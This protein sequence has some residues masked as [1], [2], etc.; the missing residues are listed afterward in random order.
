MD[1]LLQDIRY[2]LRG[3]ARSPGF[4]AAALLTLA[5]GSGANTTVFGFVNALLLRP[6]PVVSDPASLYSIFTSDFSSGPYGSTSYP[7]F[8]SLQEQAPAFSSLAAYAESSAVLRHGNTTERIRVMT[9]SSEFFSLLGV[10]AR[11][12]VLSAPD[13]AADAASAIVISD[14][15]WQRVF[16]GDEGVLGRTVAINGQPST[17]VGVAPPRFDGLNLGVAIDVWSP[18]IVRAAD[19]AARGSRGLSVL[20][21]LRDDISVPSAQAQLDAIAANLARAYPE[22]NLGTLGNPDRPRPMVLVEHSRM[23]PRFRGMVAM[24]GAVLMSA[25][26]LV[27]LVACANVAGLL[28]SRGAAR[29]REIATRL[30]LGA[31]RRRLVC[32][33]LTESLLLGIAGGALGLLFALWTSDVLPS[34]FPAE[35]ARL[36]DAGI[37]LRVLAFAALASIAT[38][39][40]FGL[41]PAVKTLRGVESPL[42]AGAGRTAEARTGL[43]RSGLVSSQ[44]ALTFVLLVACGLLVRSVANAFSA[45]IGFGTRDV[46]IANVEIPATELSPRQGASYF[47]QLLERVRTLPGVEA[48]SLVRSLSLSSLSRRRFALEGYEPRAGEDME[49]PINVVDAHY[50]DTM[51]IPIVEGRAFDGRDAEKGERTV[52]VNDVLAQRY[53]G[54]RAVGRRIQEG[55]GTVLHVIGVVRSGTLR[56]FQEPPVPTVFYPLAQSYSTRLTL[57]ARTAGEPA[58]LTDTLQTAV[59]DVNRSV[60]VFRVMTLDGHV[61]EALGAERLMAALVTAAG[62]M[63]LLLA[64]VGLYGVI[65][66]GVVRRRREI[67]VRIALG[68]QPVDVVRLVL[69]EGMMVAL[70]GIGLGAFGALAGMRLIASLLYGVSPWDAMTF[71]GAAAVLAAIAAAAAWVPAERAVRLDPAAALRQE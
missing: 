31:S 46:V 63:A 6:A 37:D 41:I 66:Y 18:L 24:V 42:Q 51:R 56:S 4:T 52:I 71:A 10:R 61:S 69:R 1:A 49:L 33:L 58:A 29:S 53:F 36:L 67:S 3:F 30:A 50:F 44:V 45:D 54:G 20:A 7:D 9:V 16:G 21:R 60:A 13:F 12:R 38:G 27:L 23:H 47:A 64:V 25:V 43:V 55:R 2:A 34:F 68:A 5:I 26:G 17:V 19:P 22:T 39:T 35:Q 40:L 32:Q 59:Q 8:L 11:G 70:A 62:A 28:L 57:V 15:L 14:H 65:A 48:A